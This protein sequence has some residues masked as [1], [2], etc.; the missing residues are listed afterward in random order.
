MVVLAAWVAAALAFQAPGGALTRGILVVGWALVALLLVAALWRGHAP[1][2]LAAFALAFVAALFWWH[3]L[4]PSNTRPWADDV[5]RTATGEVHGSLVTLHDVRNFEWRTADDYTQRWETRTYDLERI[6][7]LDMIT[8]YWAG[9]AIAHVLISFGFSDGQQL[10]FSVEI[11]RERGEKFNEI[12]GFFKEFELSIIAADE[13]DIIRVRTNVRNEDDYLYRVRLPRAD[14]R[15][16]FLAYI[17]Q[18][19]EL[20]RVP[21]FYNTITVNCTTLVYHMV[22]HIVGRLPFSYGLV[23]SGYLP[24]YVYA[25]GGLDSRYTLEEL[26]AAGRITARAR[27]ADRSADFSAAIRRGIPPLA[28]APATQ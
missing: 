27:A 21:R 12:G 10:V 6:E 7:S 23:L 16:L 3:A 15:A 18:M 4:R 25:I 28:D 22:E 8:S 11:R 24:R 14:I 9:P 17:Q 1:A 13:R 2:A 20:A 19:N 26:R 5:A